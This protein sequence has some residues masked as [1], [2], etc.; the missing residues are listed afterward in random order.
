MNIRTDLYNMSAV[1]RRFVVTSVA[2]MALYPILQYNPERPRPLT[3]KIDRPGRAAPAPAPSALPPREMAQPSGEWLNPALLSAKLASLRGQPFHTRLK[4]AE[5]LLDPFIR[6]TGERHQVDPALIKAIIMAESTFNH[7]ALSKRG[8]KGLMQLMPATALSLG[9]ED[10]FD[11]MSNL[12]GGVRYFRKLM[13][14]FDGSVE[15]A[16]AAYNAGSRKVYKYKGVPPF[17]ATRGYIK[18]VMEYYLYYK[19]SAST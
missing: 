12:D 10:A 5:R 11:P 1:T 3:F 19:E 15:L 7:R 18:K 4:K 8:A 16:L 17:K 2:L 6:Q 14:K 9:V 13:D